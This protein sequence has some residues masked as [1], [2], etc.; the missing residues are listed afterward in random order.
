[1]LAILISTQIYFL[2]VYR[3]FLSEIL[4]WFWLPFITLFNSNLFFLSIIKLD[5]KRRGNKISRQPW[6]KNNIT[7]SPS[8]I[9]SIKYFLSIIINLKALLWCTG[10]IVVL[11]PQIFYYCNKNP[12]QQQKPPVFKSIK[13]PKIDQLMTM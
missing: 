13:I 4:L 9:S 3:V 7:L 10:K 2:N 8:L 5:Y 11:K 12:K 6:S 1:M